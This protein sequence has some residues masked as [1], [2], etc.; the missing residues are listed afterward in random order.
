MKIGLSSY[1]ISRAIR[2]GEMDI[3]GAVRW[4]AENGGE[5]IEIVPSGF[6]LTGDDAL[7]DAVRKQAAE[8]G[9]DLSSYTIGANFL[10]AGEDAHETS[11][12]EYR[13]EIDR[14]KKEVDVAARLGVKL[15]RHDVGYR[16]QEM[17]SYDQYEKDLPKVAAA[18]REIADYAA[19]YG[20]TTS[21]ENHGFHFQGSERVKRLVR[22]VGRDNYRTTLDV[23]NFTCADEDAVSAT[24]NNLDIA[25]MIHFKDFYIRKSVPTDEGWF[26]S[27]HGKYLRGAIT[28]CGDLDLPAVVKAIKASGFDGYVSIEFEGMEECRQGSRI[29]LANVKA[30]FEA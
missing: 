3:L 23:G 19:Q 25:S 2:A 11:E 24:M 8:C 5:H 10:T 1:S 29:S 17:C 30:L 27:L 7:T 20:I 15:M 9:I 28:G 6:V 4:V 12:N 14:V 21:V 22:L 13:A 18:C 16:K 26:R